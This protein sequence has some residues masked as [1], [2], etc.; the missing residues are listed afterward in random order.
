[1]GQFGTTLAG[2]HSRGVEKA[3]PIVNSATNGTK[4]KENAIIAL[5]MPA[6][7]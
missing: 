3:A 5:K 6:Y 4:K 7:Y 1:V 2:W